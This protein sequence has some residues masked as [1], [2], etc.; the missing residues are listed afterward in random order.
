MIVKDKG[1]SKL[2][3][4]QF[5]SRLVLLLA[6]FSLLTGAYFVFNKVSDSKLQIATSFEKKK[7]DVFTDKGYAF[8][9]A[10]FQTDTNAKTGNQALLIHSD[11]SQHA[12]Y[13]EIENP[14]NLYANVVVWVKVL[15]GN[16]NPI[17]NVNAKAENTFN[18]SFSGFD[19]REGWSKMDY[20][21]FTPDEETVKTLVF[22]LEVQGKGLSLIHI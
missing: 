17:I 4:K 5:F 19:Q 6:G 2:N 11:S 13:L 10:Q 12:A 8:S 20:W 22:D 18:R 16:P 7:G 3:Y 14:A 21:F 9:D 1:L 15:E